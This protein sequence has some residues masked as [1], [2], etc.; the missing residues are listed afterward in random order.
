MIGIELDR[1][2]GALMGKAIE[3][4]VLINVTSDSVVRLLPPLVFSDADADSL[5]DIVSGL[6]RDFLNT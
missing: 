3:A 2:C 4:G 6:I 1:P 5:V